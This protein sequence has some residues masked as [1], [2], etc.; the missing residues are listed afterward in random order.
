MGASQ[1]K[2]HGFTGVRLL[3]F[4]PSSQ[5]FLI[6]LVPDFLRLLPQLIISLFGWRSRCFFRNS[7]RKNNCPPLAPHFS[8]SVVSLPSVP[9]LLFVALPL[10]IRYPLERC[11]SFFR[12]CPL[13]PYASLPLTLILSCIVCPAPTFV[14]PLCLRFVYLVCSRC[15][16]SHT[17]TPLSS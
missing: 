16:F 2:S 8:F 5:R 7:A 11:L 3:R 12:I 1:E 10:Q 6:V 4:T 13:V 15:P 17:V 14:L 9:P